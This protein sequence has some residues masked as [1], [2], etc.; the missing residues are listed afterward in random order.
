M[1]ARPNQTVVIYV[2]LGTL[3]VICEQLVA[4]GLRPRRQQR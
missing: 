2:G 4:H 3:P 1:L